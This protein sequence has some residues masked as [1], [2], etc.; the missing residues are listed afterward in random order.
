MLYREIIAVCS[1]IHTK[2]INALCGQNVE[3]LN[4]KLAVNIV[5]T[6]KQLATFQVRQCTPTATAVCA[7]FVLLHN[8]AVHVPHY[9]RISSRDY[10]RERTV[11]A[12]RFLTLCKTE[13]S[14]SRPDYF[15]PGET[16]PFAN[17]WQAGFVTEQSVLPRQK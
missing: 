14:V 6:G 9:T 17:K 13:W 1:Q 4:V 8:K 3:L 7:R 10:F 5:T 11:L 2:H 16:A 15:T 12:P